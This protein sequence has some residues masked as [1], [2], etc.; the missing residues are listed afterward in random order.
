MYKT[1]PTMQLWS[2]PAG[3]SWRI[4]EVIWLYGIPKGIILQGFELTSVTLQTFRYC[5]CR[6]SEEEGH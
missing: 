1:C 2:I 6:D 3:N 5:G 4:L